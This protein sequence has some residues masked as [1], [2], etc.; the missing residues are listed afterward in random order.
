MMKRKILSIL[1]TL[2]MMLT[3]LPV[4]AMAEGDSARIG[5]V[6]Y[7]TLAAAIDAAKSG[8]EIVLMQDVTE[9]VTIPA[10]K[11]ITL[12]LSNHTITNAGTGNVTLSVAGTA[13]VINGTIIG[14]A[15]NYN[16]AVGTKAT[17]GGNL[18]MNNVTATAGNSG[19]SMIDNWGTLAIESGTYTGGLNVVKNE[20]NATLTISGGT[21]ELLNASSG[22]TGVIYSAG[23]LVIND[24]TFKQSK[25][26]SKYG[27]EQ[28]VYTFKYGGNNPSTEIK[29]GTFINENSKSTA[30]TIRSTNEAT[31]YTKVTG[32]KFNKKV[33]SSYLPTGY[34]TVKN[35]SYYELGT[36][37]TGITLEQTDVRVKVGETIKLNVVS[38]TPE[39]VVIKDYSFR[40]KSGGSYVKVNSATGKVTGKAIGDAVVIA[41]PAGANSTPAECTVHVYDEAAQIGETKYG[42]L[43]E[44]IAAATDGQTVKL[45]KNVTP[46]AT[47]VLDKNLNLTLDLNNFQLTG[48]K[49]QVT[50]GS[51]KWYEYIALKIKSGTVDIKNG[52]I[53][54]RVNVYD[55]AN[56]TLEKDVTVKNKGYNSST[57]G[58]GIVVWGDGTYDKEGCKTPVLNLYGK[59]AV[60]GKKGVAIST[61]GGDASKPVINI[62]NGAEITS[63]ACSGIYLPSGAL[64]IT[65]GTITGATAVYFK[66]TDMEISGGTLIGNGKQADYNFNNNG[67]NMTGDA[68]VIDNCNYPS[69]IGKVAVTGGNFKSVNASA[70][71]SYA[72][73]GENTPL[74][75]FIS[76]G[77]F[78][79][80][81]SDYCVDGMTGVASGDAAY[82][83]TVGDKAADAK[84]AIVGSASVPAK[85]DSN[86][87]VVKK[88][89]A[90]ITGA[91]IENSN[92]AEA[93]AKNQA[94]KNTTTGETAV[95]GKTVTE[96][97]NEA[98]NGST[99]SND[100][101][102]VYQTYVNVAVSDATADSNGKITELEVNLTPMY[103]VVATTKTVVEN[104]QDIVVDGET[105]VN[106][107]VI[108]EGK[109]L[110]L[111]EIEYE[112]R[113]N[114]P[115]DFAAEI[116]GHVSVKHTK[117]NGQVE[118]Y[119]GTVTKDDVTGQ[120]YVTFTTK[121]FSPFVI[122]A[123]VASIDDVM[124]PSLAEAVA[125]ITDGQTI[126]LEAACDETVTVS[127][128]VKFTLNAN[129]LS[130]TGSINPGSR[131]TLTTSGTDTEKTYTFIYSAP[132]SSGSSSGSAAY[133]ITVDKAQNGEVT[134][135]HKSAA[136][137]TTVTLT[138]SPD[139]GYTLDNLTVFDKNDKEIKLIEKN[140][141]YIFSMP[142]SNVEVEATF[143]A[144]KSGNPFVDVPSGAYYEDAVIWAVENGI[145]GGKA[146]GLFGSNDPCTRGQIVT[147]LWRAAGSPAPKTAVNPFTDVSAD[148]YYYSAVLWAVENGITK[149]TSDTTFSPSATCSRAQ[150]VTF[151]WRSQKSPAAGSMNPFTDVSA[152][153]YYADAVLWAVKENV[154][155]GTTATTFSPN[156]NCTR[157]QIVTFIYRAL[158]E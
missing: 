112:V 42:T 147:F 113:L 39:D 154:T 13:K 106:A 68:L 81:P 139:K 102:I 124:Y 75:G 134:S 11:E 158:A 55:A 45:L 41:Q 29:G 38:T 46:A 130:F 62:F 140:G 103:R 32:G 74:T 50:S 125:N 26:T 67:A 57:D 151:L 61:N 28:V 156:T 88:A 137:G 142:A 3:L 43:E 99:T 65:G 34:A 152:D 80:D 37:I 83:Y 31:P 120:V 12:N 49:T 135:S 23:N 63:E 25:T 70:I 126:R 82:P 121:G 118:Y 90:Q 53:S 104:K 33:T 77:Y 10:A 2:A 54:G 64:T 84:P 117:D 129:G 52:N 114:V 24:G 93:A 22:Y 153:A 155:S 79:S 119:T 111:P 1:L 132:S 18:R 94:N 131:T 69:G 9:S 110:T 17:P 19:S 97:L 146:N 58:Y 6:G 5:D 128:T 91:A 20:E 95:N 86:K 116:N 133:T 87:D 105:G 73:N 143:K 21:F 4:T 100:V 96:K 76:G 157:A 36:A 136:K 101:A 145:T 60:T 150:I 47:V 56:V 148:A 51:S 107:V 78:T 109:E 89:A 127:R 27:Y 44:A 108:E 30:W 35:G 138:V 15:G 59:V 40:A 16:I 141:K 85:T 115:N 123:A 72:G 92:A 122:S 8:E 66:S 7:Q 149:G 48:H 144:V 71:G 14:G 98:T